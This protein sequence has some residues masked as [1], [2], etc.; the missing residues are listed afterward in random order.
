M[1]VIDYQTI[2]SRVQ[3]FNKEVEVRRYAK[4]LIAQLSEGDEEVPFKDAYAMAY[5]EIVQ[6]KLDYHI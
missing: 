2:K 3:R 5:L 4:E 6:P 1:E